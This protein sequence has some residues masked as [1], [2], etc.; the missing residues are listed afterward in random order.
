MGSRRTSPIGTFIAYHIMP[1]RF[2]RRECWVLPHGIMST[3]S[4]PKLGETMSN[5]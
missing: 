1:V 2:F 4:I 5:N 3:V